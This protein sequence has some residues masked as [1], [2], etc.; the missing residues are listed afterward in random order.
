MESGPIPPAVLE[1]RVKT[2]KRVDYVVKSTYG[3]QYRVQ[4]FGSTQYGTDSVSSDLDVVIIVC[5]TIHGLAMF[6]CMVAH[7]ALGP[8]ST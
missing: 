3:G 8:G 5:A 6:T 7:S 1:K 4:C 2:I